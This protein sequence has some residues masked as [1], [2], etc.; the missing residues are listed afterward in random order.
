LDQQT[1]LTI[2][3]KPNAPVGDTTRRVRKLGLVL[4]AIAL[5]TVVVSFAIL[6]DMTRVVP[7][8][9]VVAVTLTVNGVLL[10]VLIGLIAWELVGLWLAWRA[11]RAA[12]NLHLRVIG[13]F[14]AVA[15]APALIVAILASVTLDRGLD[16]WFEDRTRTIV[17]SAAMVGEAYISEHGRAIRAD[18]IAMATDVDRAKDLYD[19][20]PDRFDSFMVGQARLR[21]LPAAYLLS[22]DGTVV[23]RT[24]LAPEWSELLMPPPEAMKEAAQGEPIVL[25]PGITNQVGVIVKLAEFDDMYLYV[26]RPLDPNVLGPLRQAKAAA[27]DYRQLD[28]SRFGAQLAFAMIF[29]GVALIFL[30]AAIWIGI[31]FADRL[32]S[33]IRRLILAADYVSKGHLAV[34]VPVRRKEGD[35]AHLA[36]TFNTMTNELRGQRAELISAKDQIDRRRRF[37]EAV[38][39]GVTAGVLGID[40]EGRVTLANR[41]ATELLATPEENLIGARVFEVAPELG[42]ILE[43]AIVEDQP[44]PHQAQVTLRR[45]GREQT[46]TVRMTR[47]TSDATGRSWVVTLD[48][49]TDLVSAQRSAVWADVARRIAHEIKNP[50]TP[51]QLSAERLRRRYGKR[52]EDDRGVFDQCVDTIIRQVGDIERMV[53]EFASFARMPKP[54]PILADIG[55]ALREAVFLQSVARPEIVFSTDLPAEPVKGR[56]DQRL[57]SQAFINVVKNAGEAVEAA[58]EHRPDAGH[59]SVRLVREG[60]EVV[61]E[62]IDD[63]IGLPRE[64]RQ[65]L[66]EPYV[67]TREKGTGLG[68]AI[69]RKILEDHG[70]RIELL[71]APAVASGGHG[72]MVR[73][74]LP[75]AE[76]GDADP[77][78]ASSRSASATAGP[79]TPEEEKR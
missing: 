63:G 39:A 72:A 43:A 23:T 32:V 75:L 67:T 14:S 46:I 3:K 52:V 24:V 40:T 15:A 25:T 54:Q 70:G 33:P 57:L 49:I 29:V 38:L 30:I 71:D 20:E 60:G 50:L 37:T 53:N 42:P 2:P 69:V 44:R 27:G 9:R 73:F 55:E 17:E 76:I 5:I 47:E 64:N 26:T 12:A 4:T 13:V 16:R 59:V 1:I 51:I 11:G 36:E 58:R 77:D 41:M 79:T 31:G 74:R 22:S 65:R 45:M 56:F 7:T 28:N 62:V 21:S 10:A 8:Q 18:A 34:Q 66:L 48:D 19:S 68:L 78:A 61:V 6:T 35:L